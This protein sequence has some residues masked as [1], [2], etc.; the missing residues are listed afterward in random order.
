L[1]LLFGAQGEIMP[2][3]QTYFN[4]ILMG[5]PFLSWAMMSNHIIRAEGFPTT[6]MNVMLLPA[7]LNLILDPIFIYCLE[8]GLEGAALATII[9]YAV[10]ATY[11]IWFF[12]KGKSD[13]RIKRKNLVLH[14]NIVKEIAALGFVSFA[15]QGVISILSIVLNNSLYTYGGESYVSVYGII[16]RVMMFSMF[17]ITGI[18]QGFLPITSYN[19]GAKKYD[20][21]R[22]VIR[23]SIIYGSILAAMVYVTILFFKV[24]IVY[25]FSS[26]QEILDVTPEAMSIVFMAMPFILIQLIGSSYFQATGKA[27]PALLLTLSKQGFFLIPLVYI[28]PKFFGVYG[29]WYA[30]PIADISS[31]VLTFFFLQKVY[32]DLGKK[33]QTKLHNSQPK[34]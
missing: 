5:V 18:T 8:W 16:N 33:K 13:L 2:Y 23:K 21:V 27:L 20:R 9:S 11:T 4:I 14:S 29:I 30:F 10:S 28:L 6:A 1:L 34:S 25:L 24:E 3:A 17:P 15:R 32:V 22:E 12:I 7:I 31:T 26:E 19:F